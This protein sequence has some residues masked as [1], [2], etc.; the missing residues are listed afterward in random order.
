MTTT[1]STVT[2]FAH[3]SVPT[4]PFRPAPAGYRELEAFAGTCRTGRTA[5]EVRP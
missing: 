4:D 5:K 3:H 2:A 1:M